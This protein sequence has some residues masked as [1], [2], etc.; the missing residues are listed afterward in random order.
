VVLSSRRHRH[1]RKSNGSRCDDHSMSHRTRLSSEHPAITHASETEIVLK[2]Y[3]ANLRAERQRPR[4]SGILPRG[5]FVGYDRFAI[6]IVVRMMRGR[7]NMPG[8]QMMGISCL[9]F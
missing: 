4:V 8:I 7:D 9:R 3:S 5:L 6:S 2:S 1:G